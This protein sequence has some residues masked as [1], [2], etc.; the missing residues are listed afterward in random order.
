M[1]KV[2]FRGLNILHALPLLLAALAFFRFWRRTRFWLPKYVHVLAALAFLVGFSVF[3][4]APPDAPL[5]K[6]G[7][8]SKILF[9]LMF[10]AIVYFF[11]IFYGGQSAAFRRS[12]ATRIPCPFCGTPQNAQ[13]ASRAGHQPLFLE[14]VCSH[15][16]QTLNR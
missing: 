2:I 10:P 9:T 14:P 3:S 5:N 13:S 7:L 1:W 12:M 8:A 6:F 16:G 15:C 4:M 11:F